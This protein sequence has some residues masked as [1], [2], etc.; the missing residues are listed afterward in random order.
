[1]SGCVCVGIVFET[2]ILQTREVLV[3]HR[4]DV[5]YFVLSNFKAYIF[6]FLENKGSVK[7]EKVQ[8]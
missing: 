1:M 2:T 8:N 3:L 6:S 4:L 5:T 7:I